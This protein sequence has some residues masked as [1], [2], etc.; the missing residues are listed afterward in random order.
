MEIQQL[1]GFQAVCKY[2]SF[3]K[4]ARAIGRTQPTVSLQIQ[5]LEEELEARLFERLGPSKIKLTKEGELLLSLSADVLDKFDEIPIKFKELSGSSLHETL[6]I[7]THRSVMTY[8]LPEVVK[9]FR[10][11]YPECKLCLLNRSRS[12]IA[13]ILSEGGADIGITSLSSPNKRVSYEPIARYSRVLIGPKK[14]PLESKDNI[15]LEDISS[16]PL[17]LPMPTSNTRQKINQA[18]QEAG[19]EYQLAMEIVGRD[20][21]KTYSGLGLGLSIM[22]EYYVQKDDKK[23][24]FIKDIKNIFGESEIGIATR[25]NKKLSASSDTFIKLVKEK[26]NEKS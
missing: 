7:I 24:I 14:H 22:S 6:T 19:L 2:K 5:S 26:L 20:A 12:E 8:I 9:K 10:L 18:F 13:Q 3:T 11:L 21:I 15:S 4:A 23:K 17:I 25:G 16:Y 1:R